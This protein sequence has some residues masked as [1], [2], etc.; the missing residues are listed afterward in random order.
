MQQGRPADAGGTDARGRNAL[1]VR[2]ELQADCYAGIWGFFA[3][4][5]NKLEPGDLEEGFRAAAAVGDDSIQ[6]RAQGYVVPESFTHGSAGAAPALVQ[7]RAGVRRLAMQHLRGRRLQQPLRRRTMARR[8]PARPRSSP[9]SSRIARR[10]RRLRPVT[11]PCSASARARRSGT[12]RRA[13]G[14]RSSMSRGDRIDFYDRRVLETAERIE[15]DYRLRRARRRRRRTRCGKQVKRHFIGLLIDHK[16]PECAE[17]FFN[18]VSVKTL[19]RGYFHNRFIF[20]RPAIS[21]EHIDADPPS[22]RSYYPLQHG[23]APRA[24]RHRARLPLRAPVRGLRRAICATCWPRSARRFRGRS[25][26]RP[27]TRSRC[28]SSP[29][30]RNQTAYIVGRVVNGTHTYPFVVPVKHDAARQA[31]LRRAADGRRRS[32]DPVLR[33]SRVLPR[34]HGSA[35]G[36]RRLPARDRCPTRPPPSSTR[37]SGCR[38]PARTCSSATSCTTSSTRATSSSSRRASRAS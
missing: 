7:D 18:S 29:F 20:L 35:V 11:T 5:R 6:K 36:V 9:T 16:Q 26:S 19:R 23:P 38:R 28:C 31:L 8:S 2:L 25:G 13:T 22:Y 4:K 24:D 15:R 27:T 21:T 32:R 10:A 37:W 14:S 17:T 33:E 34:R 12:S 3:Q 30:F 1:S